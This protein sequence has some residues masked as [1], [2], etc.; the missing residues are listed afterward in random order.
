MEMFCIYRD[1]LVLDASLVVV[2]LIKTSEFCGCTS[3]V[4]SI[5]H[6]HYFMSVFILYIVDVCMY[7]E[8]NEM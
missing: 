2:V 4:I 5:T 6:E 1:I 7:C 3:R 8:I